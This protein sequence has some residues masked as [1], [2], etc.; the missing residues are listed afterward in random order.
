MSLLDCFFCS[1]SGTSCHTNQSSSFR[2]PSD[3]FFLLS[4][5]HSSFSIS[6]C[7]RCGWKSR[8]KALTEKVPIALLATKAWRSD[9]KCLNPTAG[10]LHSERT[11]GLWTCGSEFQYFDLRS[12]DDVE[13]FIGKIKVPRGGPFCIWVLYFLLAFP[14]RCVPSQSSL[15]DRLFLFPPQ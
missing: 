2:L 1:A 14:C 10:P 8:E 5:Q 4:W 15:L 13:V 9:Q 7:L 12:T 6:S 11:S 3:Y